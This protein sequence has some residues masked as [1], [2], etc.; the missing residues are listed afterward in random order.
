MTPEELYFKN[1]HLVPITLNK[2]FPN[3]KNY[4]KA[5]RIELDDLLQYG[6]TGLWMA[7]TTWD[8]S[9]TKFETYAI[10]RIKWYLL[11]VSKRELNIMKLEA[12]KKYTDNEYYGIVSMDAKISGESESNTLHDILHNDSYKNDFKEVEEKIYID[13]CLKWYKGFDKEVFKRR[14]DGLT[15]TEIANIYGTSKKNVS[16]FVRKN[17]MKYIN[18][19]KVGIL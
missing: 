11:E 13:Q 12:N 15:L 7:A 4:A 16:G 19:R 6:K 5:K 14:I 8:K 3:P 17:R 10:N 1:E 18:L 2:T 9:K